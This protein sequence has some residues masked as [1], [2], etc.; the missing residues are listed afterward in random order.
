[1]NTA[2]DVVLQYFFVF[3]NDTVNKCMIYLETFE[4][5]NSLHKTVNLG[6]LTTVIFKLI[7]N[8]LHVLKAN[9][10]DAFMY[11]VYKQKPSPLKLV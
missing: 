5:E 7:K 1:M 4:I 8:I 11:T 10:K 9:K 2:T 6:Y 3:R